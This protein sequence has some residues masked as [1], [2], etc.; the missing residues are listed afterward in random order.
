[1]FANLDHMYLNNAKNRILQNFT[2]LTQAYTAVQ[3]RGNIVN[4]S[5]CNCTYLNGTILL[6]RHFYALLRTCYIHTAPI[7]VLCDVTA[8]NGL[9]PS[10][11]LWQHRALK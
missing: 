5:P 1:M 4:R 8:K 10:L 2:Q 9:R 3:S 6:P 7:I 11:E